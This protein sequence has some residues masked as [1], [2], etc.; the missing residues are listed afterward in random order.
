MELK[1]EIII[2]TEHTHWLTSDQAWHYR[3]LPK[4]K[5]SDQLDLY[6]EETAHIDELSSELETMLGIDICLKP[7][8]VNQIS[9]LLSKY[10]I[11]DN[12]LQGASLR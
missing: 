10:Y 6:C 9:R 5:T 3:V 12:A 7:I 8:P 1:D 4:G 11:K 2:L